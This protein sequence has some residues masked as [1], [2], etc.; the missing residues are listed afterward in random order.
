MIH[1]ETIEN[2]LYTIQFSKESV[3]GIYSGGS[4]ISWRE[5]PTRLRFEFCMSTRKN[6]D[7]GV[8][9][10]CFPW[11]AND[12]SV[13][14]CENHAVLTTAHF[15]NLNVLLT[16]NNNLNHFAPIVLPTQYRRSNRFNF[17]VIVPLNGWIGIPRNKVINQPKEENVKD[18]DKPLVPGSSRGGL[19][20][21]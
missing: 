12:L 1:L 5:V 4:R 20:R 10:R 19:S 9:R 8:R 11:S 16:L 6:L 21:K 17:I 7:L 15:T 18:I 3:R 14:K 2:T 13:R